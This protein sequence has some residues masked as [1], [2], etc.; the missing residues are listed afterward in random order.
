MS[1]E[2]IDAMLFFISIVHKGH[3]KTLLVADPFDL[4]DFRYRFGLELLTK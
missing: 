1:N 3:T 4:R 2:S